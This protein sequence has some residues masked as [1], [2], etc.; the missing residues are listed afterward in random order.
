[1]RG[2]RAR[3]WGGLA[4]DPRRVDELLSPGAALFLVALPFATALAAPQPAFAEPE[5]SKHEA[6][7]PPAPSAGE[8][9]DVTDPLLTPPP[10]A[11]REV[12]TW[13]DALA[14]L[15]ASSP[16]YVTGYESVV[17]AAAQSRIA[18][19]N[20]LPTLNGSASYLHQFFTLSIPISGFVVVTPAPNVYALQGVAQWNISPKAIYAVGTADRT[21][22][23]TKL[24]FEDKRRVIASAV[25]AAMLSTLAAAR[26][27]ELNRVGLRAALE[28]LALT[29]TRLEYG[30]G[31]ALDVDRAEQDVAS[32]RAMIITGDEAL[33]QSREALGE[34]LGSPLPTAAPGDLQLE[35]FEAAVARTCHLNDELERRPDVKAARLGVEIAERRLTEADLLYSPTLLLASQAQAATAAPLAPLNSW[36]VSAALNVPIFDGGVRYGARRDAKAAL[37]QARQA[38]VATRL[39]ALVSAAQAQ[40]AVSVDEA[41][42]D[43]ALRQRDLART[44]DRR[45]RDSYAQGAGTSLDLV[46]SAQSLRQAEINLVLLDIQVGQARANTVLAN[47]ECVY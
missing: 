11:A 14:L 35:E 28:R 32:A 29:K 40:R 15:R 18:L 8:A 26:V 47:A 43:V 4:W 6:P 5:P 21:T 33:R 37:E 22:E 25:A 10:P 3:T 34:A 12:K 23:L 7:A 16:D 44:I 9:P 30:Q 46:I 36:N 45:T 42:R 41:S 20:A 13:D 17:R 39:S 19:G 27:A 38:L 1:M 2:L 24:S 31:T